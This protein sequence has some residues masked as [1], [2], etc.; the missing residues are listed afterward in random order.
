MEGTLAIAALRKGRRDDQRW[1]SKSKE[2]I[3]EGRTRSRKDRKL[4]GARDGANASSGLHGAQC[5]ARH[6][7]PGK[8]QRRAE[9]GAG[10]EILVR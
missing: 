4:L 7:R 6:C 10:A 5:P 1:I 8:G 9:V 2:V 3:D